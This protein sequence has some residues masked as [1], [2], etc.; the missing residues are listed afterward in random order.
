MVE[1]LWFLALRIVVWKEMMLGVEVA[2]RWD[3]KEWMSLREQRTVERKLVRLVL[4]QWMWWRGLK[5]VGRSC[6]R[7]SK[8][9]GKRK[10]VDAATNLRVQRR[11]T[12]EVVN[13][14]VYLGLLRRC[15]EPALCCFLRAML[16]FLLAQRRHRWLDSAPMTVS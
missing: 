14:C 8:C 6:S 13:E 4:L 16:L 7:G 10:E 11:G 5:V 12:E 3:L 15:R 1:P 2:K 9:R